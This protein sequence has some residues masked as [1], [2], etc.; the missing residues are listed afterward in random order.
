MTLATVSQMIADKF[1][2]AV[3]TITVDT[4]LKEDLNI[5]SLDSVEMVMELEDKFSISIKDEDAAKFVTVGDIV[6]YIDAQAQ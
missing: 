2:V 6:N 5:D 4:K 1:Q 3:D